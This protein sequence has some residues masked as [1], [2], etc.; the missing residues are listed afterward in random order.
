MKKAQAEREKAQLEAE[1]QIIDETLSSIA[2]DSKMTNGDVARVIAGL[3]TDGESKVSSSRPIAIVYTLQVDMS[4]PAESASKRHKMTGETRAETERKDKEV[5]QA[6]LDR[7]LASARN[8]AFRE[9]KIHRVLTT[10]AHHEVTVRIQLEDEQ[11]ALFEVGVFEPA[12]VRQKMK[13][14][15]RA[16]GDPMPVGATLS[17]YDYQKR[18]WAGYER[19][20]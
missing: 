19:Y 18:K 15:N 20:R 9:M 17:L 6:A 7:A 12:K 13:E 3:F 8:A 11:G 14:L 4:K 10:L 2:K 1:S 5:Y 16:A